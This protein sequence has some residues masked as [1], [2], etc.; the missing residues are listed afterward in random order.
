MRK[1]DLHVA[2]G[3]CLVYMCVCERTYVPMH[4]CGYARVYAYVRMHVFVCM[5]VC[6][7]VLSACMLAGRG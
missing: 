5:S 6:M 1:G 2:T 4:A 7:D 3:I